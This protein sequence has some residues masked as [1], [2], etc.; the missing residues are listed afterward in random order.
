MSLWNLPEVQTSGVYARDS[1]Q[2]T[3]TVE[4]E[5]PGLP[6]RVIGSNPER[7][8]D[9]SDW[10]IRVDEGAS[11]TI[12]AA[13]ASSETYRARTSTE[14]QPAEVAQTLVGKEV[15]EHQSS[16]PHKGQRRIINRCDRGVRRALILAS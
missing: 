16:Q 10:K 14:P 15:P 6:G 5:A 11:K 2:I 1:F 4:A 12:L 7:D 3:E 8:G 9:E 13:R